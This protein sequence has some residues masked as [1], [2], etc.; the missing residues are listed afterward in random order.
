MT[1]PPDRQEMP[2]Y[3]LSLGSGWQEQMPPSVH[4]YSV[5]KCH[6]EM[7]LGSVNQPVKMKEPVYPIINLRSRLGQEVMNMEIQSEVPPV[8]LQK[9]GKVVREISELINKSFVLLSTYQGP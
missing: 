3:E 9:G 7:T 2:I 4:I 5:R 1:S 6:E 8:S